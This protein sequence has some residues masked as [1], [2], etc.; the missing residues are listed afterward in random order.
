MYFPVDK[1]PVEV[2]MNDYTT[3]VPSIITDGVS[4]DEA[5]NHENCWI[6]NVGNWPQDDYSE[7]YGYMPNSSHG[8]S[9]AF[10]GGRYRQKAFAIVT[11]G[12]LTLGMR[13][14]RWALFRQRLVRLGRLEAHLP[15]P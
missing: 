5:R 15:C 13:H 14:T 10:S 6:D 7:K 11:D 1:L 8:A 4:A 2:Y 3:V 12:K 9:I